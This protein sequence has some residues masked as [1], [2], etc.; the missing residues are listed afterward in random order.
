M[1]GALAWALGIFSTSI[2]STLPLGARSGGHAAFAASLSNSARVYLPGSPEFADASV[3]WSAAQTPRY[4]A[5]VKVATEEDVQ[6]TILYANYYSKPF[7]A[8]SGGHG[9]TT[10]IDGVKNGIGI[11]MGGMDNVSIVD[12][13]SAAVIQGGVSNGDLLPYLWSHGKQTVTTGCDCVGYI[14]PI[15]GGGH[16]WL[17]G[18]YG[19]AAD[20]LMSAR[21]V[22]ANGTALTVSE[23][24]NPDL[25]WAIRGAGHNFGVVTQ[26]K[27]KVY[28][29]K[30]AEK[31]WATSGFFFTHDRLEDVFAL[32]NTWLHSTTVQP[33]GMVHYAVFAH[34][35][36]VDPVNPIIVMWIY[37][38]GAAIPP[39]YTDPLQALAPFAVDESVGDLPA[40]N[41]HLFADR[42]GAACAKGFSRATVPVGLDSYSLPAL[43]RVLDMFAAMPSPFRSS[44]MMLEGYATHRVAQI[45]APSTAFPDRETR[46]LLSPVLTWP[47]N[48]SLDAA[49]WELGSKIRDTLVDV[50]ES[51]KTLKAYVNYARGDETLQEMYGS[52]PW[53]LTKLRRLKREY[54]PH[55][56]FNF[57]APIV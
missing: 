10:M 1:S 34:N 14:A 29:V 54:D 57:Y 15:L 42:N 24:S 22:L 33:A 30:P 48:A 37:W 46:L 52:E 4:D 31:Q 44:V 18:R 2:L 5:I 8:I 28:T 7:L 45:P 39:E 50:S 11:L 12:D 35:P 51:D 23:A 53:R 16:G 20:Q 6:K 38:Q 27:M 47:R 56:R 3:R 9:T 13:G 41:T 43:R 36:A 55:G 19:L 40:L 25:F 21:M 49:G 26:V 32:A 17:Q